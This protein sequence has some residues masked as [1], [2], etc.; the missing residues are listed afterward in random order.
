MNYGIAIAAIFGGALRAEQ[1]AQEPVAAQQAKQ[2]AAG[3]RTT[4]TPTVVPKATVTTRYTP[5]NITYFTP[6]VVT[7]RNPFGV[8]IA[9]LDAALRT[10]LGIED[11]VGVVVTGVKKDSSAAKAGLEPYDLVL[12]IGEQKIVGTKQF[13]ELLENQQGKSVTFRIVRKA[14]PMTLTFEVPNM[15]VYSMVQLEPRYRTEFRLTAQPKH[16]ADV[17]VEKRQYRIGV[18]LSQADET[19]RSQLR[20]AAGEGLVVTDV[21]ADSPAAKAG[22]QKNDVLTRLG[23]TRLTTSEAANAIIQD[24]K[25]H[26]LSVTLLRAGRETTLE[27]TP[28]L[29]SDASP[30]SVKSDL[31]ELIRHRIREKYDVDRAALGDWLRYNYDGRHDALRWLQSFVDDKTASAADAAV[32]SAAVDQLAELKKQFAELQMTLAKLEAA[33][34]AAP[35]EQ[36]AAPQEKK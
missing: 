29:T 21:I 33:L 9:E 5:V 8:E 32:H 17:H 25:D 26:K 15:P 11:E 23:E 35:K 16:E 10:Q 36:P 4:V 22:I 20:L 1:P 12:E 7:H 27:V 30:R 24:A 28:Q 18:T 13:H 3:T 19:L 14:K 2:P 31:D 34:Q 6:V